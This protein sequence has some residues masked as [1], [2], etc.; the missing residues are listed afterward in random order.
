[1]D[2][3]EANGIAEM[4][5]DFRDQ[6]FE[7]WADDDAHRGGA[8]VRRNVLLFSCCANDNLRNSR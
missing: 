4:C 1:M 2:V 8:T 7:D 6:G 5:D 3:V